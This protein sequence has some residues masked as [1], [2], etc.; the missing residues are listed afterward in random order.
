MSIVLNNQLAWLAQPLSWTSAHAASTPEAAEQ[1]TMLNDLQGNILDGHGREHTSNLFIRFNAAKRHEAR[2]FL[3]HVA[4]RIGSALDQLFKAR[5][6]QTQNKDGG[7]FV[8]VMLTA[9]GYDALGVRKAKP[10]DAAF[11]AGMKTRNLND[12]PASAWDL[13]FSGEI[14]AMILIAND[15]ET[16]RDDERNAMIDSIDATGGAIVLLNRDHAEDGNV[17]RNDAKVGIEHFGY[18]DGRS[19]PLALVEQVQKEQAEAGVPLVWDP[20]IPLSQL[21]LP[22]PGGKHDVSCGSYFV[23]RKLEQNVKGFKTREDELSRLL[24]AKY[25]RPKDSIDAGAAVVGR[26]EN[27]VPYTRTNDENDSVLAG[28]PVT[29]NFNYEQQPNGDTAGLR[30]P[31]AAHIRKSNPRSDTPDSKTHLMARR[32]IPYGRRDDKPNDN[33]LDNKPEGGVGLLFMAYQSDLEKQFEFTQRSWVNN[34]SFR[35]PGVGIDPVIGQPS[36]PSGQ[37]WTKIYGKELSD[38]TPDESFSG[39]VT[40]RGGE[41]FFA[42][43]ISF[44]KSL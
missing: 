42:P 43:S 2:A 19:Q 32:G 21:L 9:A 3:A 4:Q 37:K 31:F 7:T 44:L 35:N 10:D 1:L 22:C 38:G 28:H 20:T 40:M 15:D 27:G 23:F 25:G 33:R 29:N 26:F 18:V 39:F 17:L 14:H 41:Y 11:V 5:A 6:Y 34:S 24:E 8:A 36:E 13:T 30:C 12:P 16:A